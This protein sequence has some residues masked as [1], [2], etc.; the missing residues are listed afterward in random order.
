M[1]QTVL[2]SMF[3]ASDREGIGVFYAFKTPENIFRVDIGG[4][5]GGGHSAPQLGH[6]TMPLTI[7]KWPRYNPGKSMMGIEPGSGHHWA[8]HH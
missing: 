1:S 5:G 4:L 6:G 7:V 3:R 2:W 8:T